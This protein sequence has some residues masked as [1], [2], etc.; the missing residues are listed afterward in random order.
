[1]ICMACILLAR[2]LVLYEILGGVV[3]IHFVAPL[4]LEEVVRLRVWSWAAARGAVDNLPT[5][6]GVSPQSYDAL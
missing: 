4:L 1:M 6:L 3:L 5:G 2:R